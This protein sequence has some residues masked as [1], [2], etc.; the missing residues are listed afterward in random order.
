MV[1]YEEGSYE[2]LRADARETVKNLQREADSYIARI[3]SLQNLL[4]EV[5]TR[6]ADL[7][8]ENEHLK[9]FITERDKESNLV[10]ESMMPVLQEIVERKNK[11]SK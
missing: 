11:K 9:D 6:N 4:A 3:L 1:F 7:E 5:M 8:L 2:R 10:S